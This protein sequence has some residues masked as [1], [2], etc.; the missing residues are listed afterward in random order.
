M[1]WKLAKEEAQRDTLG[2]V[3]YHLVESLRFA[4]VLLQP[5][6][7]Q[8][9][10]KIFRQL[11]VEEEQWRSWN[12]LETFAAFPAGGRIQK[13]SPIFP[14]LDLEE[15]VAYIVGTMGGELVKKQEQT[16][17]KEEKGKDASDRLPEIGIDDFSKLDL[18]VAEVVEA[19]KHP[20]ADRLLVLQLDV[21]EEKRQVVSGIAEHYSPDELV[22][23]KV[24]VVANLKPVKLRGEVS[25]GMILAASK[26]KRLTLAT[27][28]EQMP[29]GSRVK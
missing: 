28:P 6:F 16:S 22:G 27:V 14:R 7:T 2:S 25:K 23:K 17:N 9:P 8:T 1:P 11:G 19:K 29:N 4:A 5:F 20:N 12:S 3:L 18:R 15:E 10:K 26:G 24:I 21:G 13:A